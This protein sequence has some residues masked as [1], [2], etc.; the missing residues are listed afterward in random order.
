MSGGC[1]LSQSR[2][3][4]VRV[5]VSLGFLIIPFASSFLAKASRCW[6]ASTTTFSIRS[7][8]RMLVIVSP[9]APLS[10]VGR[11]EARGGSSE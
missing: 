7:R 2:N 6:G 4:D 10:G 1:R 5:K 8:P 3:K 9:A 11:G